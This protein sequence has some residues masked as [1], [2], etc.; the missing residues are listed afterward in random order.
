MQEPYD[1]SREIERKRALS[2]VLS[3]SKHQERKDN[4]VICCYYLPFLGI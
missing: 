3:H 2:M 1:V 4:E